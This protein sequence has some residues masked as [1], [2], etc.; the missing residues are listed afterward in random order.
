MG[1]GERAMK[2]IARVGRTCYPWIHKEMKD[3]GY[4]WIKEKGY[5][6]KET[7]K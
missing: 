4:T 5:W 3:A 1:R 6:Q 2:I 7:I